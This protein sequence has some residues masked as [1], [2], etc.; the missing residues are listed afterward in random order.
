MSRQNLILFGL[1]AFLGGCHVFDRQQTLEPGTFIRY[2]CNDGSF[3]RAL[4]APDGSYVTLDDMLGNR[5]QLAR[6]GVAGQEVRY[7][8]R[9]V[10][11]ALSGNTLEFSSIRNPKR[12]L[13]CV[14][15]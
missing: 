7:T 4:L 5:Y 2:D 15:R 9:V 10:T 13:H 14:M 12:V 3:V 6:S 1:A 8:D 11:L